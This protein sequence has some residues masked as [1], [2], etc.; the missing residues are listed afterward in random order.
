[1]RRRRARSWSSRPLPPYQPP[2]GDEPD[3]RD[4]GVDEVREDWNGE[5]HQHTEGIDNDG[6]DA[7]EVAA[8]RFF[9]I[10]A[11]VGANDEPYHDVVGDASQQGKCS[12]DHGGPQRIRMIARPG[13]AYWNQREPEEQMEIGP[14]HRAVDMGRR[15]QQ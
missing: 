11:V 3:H 1:M 15:A 9:D 7:L 14:H 4:D 5:R 2:V 12:V 6:Y 13:G 8:N 10:G